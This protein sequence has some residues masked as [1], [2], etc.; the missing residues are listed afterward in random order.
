[1]LISNTAY[2]PGDLVNPQLGIRFVSYNPATRILVFRDGTG[3][4]VERRH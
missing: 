1:V 2:A 3:A 4:S